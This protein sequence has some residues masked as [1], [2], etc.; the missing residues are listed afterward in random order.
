V[1]AARD[2][3]ATPFVLVALGLVA[4]AFTLDAVT[5]V[6]GTFGFIFGIP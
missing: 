6:V 1:Q 5:A 3:P 2:H 4:V